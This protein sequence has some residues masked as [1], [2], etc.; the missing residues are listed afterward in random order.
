LLLLLL[1]RLPVAPQ[2]AEV[3]VEVVTRLRRRMRPPNTQ[4]LR[5]LRVVDPGRAVQVTQVVPEEIT[6]AVPVAQHPRIVV[7]EVPPRRIAA[8]QVMRAVL[9][10]RA[11]TGAVKLLAETA[12]VKPQAATEVVKRL[13]ATAAVKRLAAIAVV[14]RLAAIAVVRMPEEIAA[15]RTPVIAAELVAISRTAAAVSR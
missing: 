1:H 4:L 8:R 11:G 7:L 2:K 9:V 13:A 10:R 5:A 14:K 12:A 6:Q 15:A 3:V